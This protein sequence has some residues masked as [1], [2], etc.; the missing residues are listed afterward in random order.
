[1]HLTNYSINK[2]NKEYKSNDDET[3]CVGHK[4][5]LKALW[6]YLQ[7]KGINTDKIWENIVD[8]VIKTI[9]WYNFLSVFLRFFFYPNI[10]IQFKKVI[11]S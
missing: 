11:Q 5:T 1:M 3:A 10:F 6:A 9:I 8:L 7:K 2:T 4:W